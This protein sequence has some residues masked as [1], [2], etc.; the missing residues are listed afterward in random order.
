MSMRDTLDIRSALLVTMVVAI[1]GCS[2]SETPVVNDSAADIGFC[3]VALDAAVLQL[4]GFRKAYQ[5]PTQIPRS[6]ENNQTRLVAPSDWTSGFVAGSFWYLFESTND[7]SWR[8]TAENW[9]HVLEDQKNNTG[10]HD[11][12]FMM[13]NSFGN[14]LRLV[15]SESYKPVLIQTADSLMTRYNRTVGATRSWDHGE[16]GFPVIIDNMMNLELLYAASELSGDPKYAD[17]A[18]AHALTTL[19]NHFRPDHS[20]FHVV[21]YDPDTG[22]VVG[23]QT[24]QGIADDS[25]WSRGQ[26]W[27]LYGYTMAYRFTQDV[28]FLELAENIADYY[29]NHPNLPEDKVPY[30]DFDAPDHNGVE[31]VRDSSAAA[32]TASALLE[33]ADFVQEPHAATYRD[34]ALAMLASLSSPSYSAEAGENGH[35]LL[36]HATGRWQANDEVDATLNY[37]DYYYLEALLRCT[38]LN[39]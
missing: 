18:T 33:L 17:A 19:E 9:T 5:D 22:A 39:D 24:H 4:D 13:Y 7:A 28:R 38:H 36:K 1:C 29:L 8:A 37:A 21:D 25:A 20:S 11:V 2:N 27:G 12:G 31:N 26:A 3:S 14:G 10:I 23:K 34:G 30:F 35:F 15:G 6:F 32:V 16:W